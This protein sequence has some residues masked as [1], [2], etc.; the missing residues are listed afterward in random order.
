M[1]TSSP[2]LHKRSGCSPIVHQVPRLRYGR[3]TEHGNPQG[4]TLGGFVVPGHVAVVTRE[5]RV[6]WGYHPED[7]RKLTVDET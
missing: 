7:F 5:G 6:V 3:H 2:T 4:D 1:A